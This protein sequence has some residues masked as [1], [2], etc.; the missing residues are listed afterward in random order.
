MR[1]GER[2]ERTEGAELGEDGGRMGAGDVPLHAPDGFV[3]GLD[4]HAGGF[5]VDGLAHL[6]RVSREGWAVAC[7]GSKQAG[8]EGRGQRVGD[9]QVGGVGVAWI[10]Q[11]VGGFRN[12]GGGHGE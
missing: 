9:P 11:P 10:E 1:V 3:A 2:E 7:E 12:D 6:R 8:I 5:V 4:V